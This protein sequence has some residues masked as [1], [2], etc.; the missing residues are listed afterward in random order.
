MDFNESAL[1]DER[2]C[3]TLRQLASLGVRLALD[4]FGTGYSSLNHLRQHPIDAIKLDGSFMKAVPED[5]QATLLTITVIDMAHALRK[6]VIAEGI[7]TPQQ[8]RFLC[9]HGCDLAQG[10]LLAPPLGLA[11]LDDLLSSRRSAELLLS[12][13][14]G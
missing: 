14:A 8:L 10:F 4:D 9:E 3:R 1:S 7:E 6:E 11:E 2:A 5:P 13:V 12:R